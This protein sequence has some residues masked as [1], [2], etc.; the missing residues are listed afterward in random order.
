LAA[1]SYFTVPARLKWLL[2]LAELSETAALTALDDLRDRALLIE[3][4][5]NGTWLL[6]TL[7]GRFLRQRR[8]EAVLSAGMRLEAEVYSLAVSCGNAENAPF[9]ELE[10]AW[11]KVQAAIPLLI[12]GDNHR[13][14][15]V[16]DSL[17]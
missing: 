7:T 2:P 15:A 8:P 6:P 5:G 17:L 3:D 11:P 10:E 16:C 4:E 14:Q 1:L 12:E 13:L 9:A